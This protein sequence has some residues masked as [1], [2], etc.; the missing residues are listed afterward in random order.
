MV[1]IGLGLVQDLMIWLRSIL[2]WLTFSLGMILRTSLFGFHPTLKSIMLVLLG[3]LLY[4]MGTLF[5]DMHLSGSK[6]TPWGSFILFGLSSLAD[7]QLELDCL[8]GCPYLM[9]T[10]YCV[11]AWNSETIYSLISP[12]L[13]RSR[14]VWPFNGLLFLLVG[15]LFSIGASVISI[16]PD[17]RWSILRSLGY[18]VSIIFEGRETWGYKLE[19]LVTV[20]L[21]FN[22]LRL[23]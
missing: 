18:F 8:N 6:V 3:L 2:T 19:P 10:V 7:L 9:L 11:G 22:P 14:W 12:V 1:I 17:A 4:L 15:M 23:L 21:L 16:D 13:M 20:P 5:L